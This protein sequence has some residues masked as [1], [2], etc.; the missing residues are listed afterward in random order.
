AFFA[1]MGGIS[2]GPK[3]IFGG[4]YCVV[5][6]DGFLYFTRVSQV[7]RN[8]VRKRVIMDKS[9]VESLGKGMVFAQTIW[10]LLHRLLRKASRLPITLLEFRDDLHVAITIMTYAF[11]WHKPL[12][13]REP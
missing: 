8:A 9:K 4:F 11:W 13:V 6:Y 5:T 3:E 12:D 2:L 1:G 10:T 7:P